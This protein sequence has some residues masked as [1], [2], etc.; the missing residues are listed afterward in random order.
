MGHG[1]D[2]GE[3]MRKDV[4]EMNL[5][6]VLQSISQSSFLSRHRRET[7]RTETKE[8]NESELKRREKSFDLS[9]ADLFI[10]I[11]T[12]DL[13]HENRF[14]FGAFRFIKK[15]RGHDEDDGKLSG[16]CKELR[17]GI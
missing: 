3:E 14:S 1:A 8:M 2:K 10:D 15:K 17:E 13:L 7:M 5:S 9:S 6:P 16:N 12:G 11:R 4:V